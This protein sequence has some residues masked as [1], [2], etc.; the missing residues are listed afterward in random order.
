[1]VQVAPLQQAPVVQGVSAQVTPDPW[2]TPPPPAHRPDVVSLQVE[3]LQHAPAM[4]GSGV[5]ETLSPW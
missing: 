3:P 4:Q 1:M 5:H 2:N